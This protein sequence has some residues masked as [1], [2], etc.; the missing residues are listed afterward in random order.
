MKI[1]KPAVA[2]KFYPE[3]KNE[4]KKLIN[5]IYL[6]EKNN[7]DLSLSKHKIIGGI[8]PHAGYMFSAYEAVHFFDIIK[9]SSL[10]YDTIIIINPN[11]SSYGYN[12][13]LDSNDCWET[14][15]GNVSLDT[16]FMSQ[17][18]FSTS[19]ET[20]RYEH[21]GEVML[22]LLQYFLDYDFKIVPITMSYQNYENAKLLAEEIYKACFKIEKNF[23]IIASSDFSH[24]VEPEYG[25]CL[26]NFVLDNILNLD[27]CAINNVVR[28]KHLSVCGYGPIMA[29]IEFSKLISDN[30]HTKILRRGNS[31]EIIPSQEV[32]DYVSMLFY[33]H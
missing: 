11:H 7:I 30:P 4:L 13:E 3:E 15:L 23:L 17:L 28:K 22:P 19:T 1:R 33:E 25:K 31:G 14:P 18:P 6:K 29:L 12:T 8:V 5:S 16:E 32:V 26:D 10:Q 24:Y 27:A 21:S 20:H 9:K 2:G